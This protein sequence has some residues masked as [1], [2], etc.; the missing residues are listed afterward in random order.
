MTICLVDLENQTIHTPQ[1]VLN[2][3]GYFMNVQ[4]SF[5]KR[6]FTYKHITTCAWLLRTK[7]ILVFR[8]QQDPFP[9]FPGEVIKHKVSLLKVVPAL[10]ALRLKYITQR[11]RLEFQLKERSKIFLLV[12]PSAMQ[13][14]MCMSPLIYQKRTKLKDQNILEKLRV[15]FIFIVRDLSKTSITS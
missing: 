8:L 11:N 5:I 12:R 13:E 7:F 6:N 4:Y 10:S 2:V 9:L 15:T 14:V 1:S 3:D